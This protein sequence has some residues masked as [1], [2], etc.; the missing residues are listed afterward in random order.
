M[1]SV[2]YMG[3]SVYQSQNNHVSIYKD[4]HMVM[5]SQCDKWKTDKEL[6]EM[7]HHFLELVAAME[8]VNYPDRTKMEG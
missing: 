1:R 7:V 2:K 3:Y 4:G 8:S 6:R 5:H